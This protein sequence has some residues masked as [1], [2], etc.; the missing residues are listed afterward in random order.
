[1]SPF[2]FF[3]SDPPGWITQVR[4]DRSGTFAGGCQ[5]AHLLGFALRLA[6]EFLLMHDRTFKNMNRE[7][8]QGGLGTRPGNCPGCWQVKGAH[9][10]VMMPIQHPVPRKIN[11]GGLGKL[12]TKDCMYKMG[13]RMEKWDQ[14][15]DNVSIYKYERQGHVAAFQY[16]ETFDYP[17]IEKDPLAPIY[18]CELLGWSEYVEGQENVEGT[19]DFEFARL[20]L[21]LEKCDAG[22]KH[23]EFTGRDSNYKAA[24]CTN[25]I[26]LPIVCGKSPDEMWVRFIVGEPLPFGR[27]AEVPI[28]AYNVA[29]LLQT[30]AQGDVEWKNKDEVEVMVY[31]T[32][33]PK[34]T[35]TPESG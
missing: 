19:W 16:E 2:F 1:M 26:G 25:D 23:C 28:R 15:E 31:G 34:T 22:Q 13:F 30:G 14:K 10:F 24:I 3:F 32:R 29:H 20:P 7:N 4:E 6:D 8:E 11:V 27:C 9:D 5:Y 18:N 21:K 33:K 12:G 35:R 17:M